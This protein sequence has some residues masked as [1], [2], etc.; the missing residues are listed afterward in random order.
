MKN[1]KGI[2]LTALIIYVLIFSATLALLASLTN[3][4]YPRLGNIDSNSISPIEFNQF[5][6]NF[7]S[8]IKQSTTAVVQNAENGNVKIILSNGANY[9]YVKDEMSLYKNK[10]KISNKIVQFSG[11]L[12]NI[13]GKNILKITIATGK[14]SNNITF[15]KTIKYVLKYW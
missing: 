11:E 6:Y 7:V 8:D 15:G 5:N 3:Y 14:D 13:N 2:T 4:L 9:T 12:E 1:E 10:N